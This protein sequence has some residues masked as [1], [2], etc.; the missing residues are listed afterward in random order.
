MGRRQ[1]SIPR[2]VPPAAKLP[3]VDVHQKLSE[4]EQLLFS[5]QF[6]D[7]DHPVFSCDC[8]G[9]DRSWF[10]G[11][12]ERLKAVSALKLVACIQM[13]ALRFHKIDWSRVSDRFNLPGP[14]L[15]QVEEDSWQFALSANTGRVHGFIVGNRFF[16]HWLDPDHDLYPRKR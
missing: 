13:E 6:Y 16:V 12:L 15:Q 7:P 5:F 9:V 14:M 10:E 1:R 3:F 4:Q 2:A 8:E 11:L